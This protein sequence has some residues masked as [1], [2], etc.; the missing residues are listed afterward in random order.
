MTFDEVYE[1]HFDFVWKSLRR[2]GVP[3]RDLP[4]VAQEVF[5]VVHRRLSSFEERAKLTTWL[6]Q[7]CFHAARDRG[8]RAHVRREVSDM[9]ALEAQPAHA[10][11]AD[12]LLERRDELALFDAVLDGMSADQRAVFVMFEL[13]DMTGDDIA[14][15]LRLPLGTV[16]SRIRLAREAF[17]RGVA[18]VTAR[19]DRRLVIRE[20]SR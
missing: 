7:I 2:L 4:D 19:N 14:E 1:R 6:F 13:S 15:T 10:E 11:R 18:R 3:D 16:Y 5:V 8:R 17:R 9:T 20:G 12:Q